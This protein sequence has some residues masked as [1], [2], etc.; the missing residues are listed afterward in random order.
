MIDPSDAVEVG[1]HLGQALE[2]AGHPYAIGGALAY[3]FFGIP[4]ATNDVDLNVF[5][6]ADKLEAVLDTLSGAGV[7]FDRAQALKEATEQGMFLGRFGQMRIDVFV[8][9]IP[10]SWEAARTRV[11]KT[12]GGQQLWFLSAEAISIFKLL[13]FR[14]KD[15]IDL[16]RLVSVQGKRL[17]TA[18][19][20]R[21]LVEMM[22]EDDVRVSK[23]DELLRNFLPP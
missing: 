19:V 6:E 3:G 20:R 11:R 14:G 22:G 21:Q 23:W 18:Y 12:I 7:A 4:R 9:S 13:F 15:L 16:E 8:P 10:F 1:A 5:V 17:D 2:Q